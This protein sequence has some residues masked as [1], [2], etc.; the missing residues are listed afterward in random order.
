MRTTCRP[1]C[2]TSRNT[3][4]PDLYKVKHA[5]QMKYRDEKQGKGSAGVRMGST[6]GDGACGRN[7]T[8]YL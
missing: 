1:A 2:P 7:P 6:R 5:A 4:S 3:G 8:G